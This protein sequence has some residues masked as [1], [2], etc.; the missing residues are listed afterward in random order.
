[1]RR[2]EHPSRSR[3]SRPT[4]VGLPLLLTRLA[5]TCLVAGCGR[6]TRPA[7]STQKPSGPEWFA[8]ITAQSGLSFTHVTGTNYF[9]PDQMGSGLAVFDYDQDGRLDVYFVQNGGTSAPAP[10][11]LFHQES[12]GTFRNVSA[13]SGL[14]VVGR[15]MGAIAGDVNNDGLPD[16]V[17]TEYGATR[18]FQNIGGGKF[19]EVTREAGL[20]DRKSVV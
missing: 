6:D 16:V 15:G 17:V 2:G 19:R 5:L 9:M 4:S 7:P 14:D 11:Q 3:T 20:E 10:N 12:D 1:M 8:D 18:L 13:G